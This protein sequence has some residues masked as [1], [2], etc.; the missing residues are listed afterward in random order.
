MD[1]WDLRTTW[2]RVPGVSFLPLMYRRQGA[3]E[4]SNPEPPTDMGQK[5]KAPRK[6]VIP[7]QGTGIRMTSQQKI[8]LAILVLFQLS[9]NE[10][11]LPTNSCGFCRTEPGIELPH[12]P[13]HPLHFTEADGMRS[14]LFVVPSR[15]VIFPLLPSR[16]RWD[17][18]VPVLAGQSRELVFY[19]L[20]GRSSQCSETPTRRV[21]VGSIE[22]V[23]LHGHSASLGGM[24]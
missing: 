1:P 21:S 3:T 24:K 11:T 14:L 20:P 12:T 4:A 8:L 15:Q 19:P 5:R 13:T 7:S 9:T 6:T 23:S 2:Q 16:T 17:S 10:K 22:E 18:H